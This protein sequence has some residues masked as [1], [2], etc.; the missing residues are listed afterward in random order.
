MKSS[1][2]HSSYWAKYTSGIFA[3][4]Q[5]SSEGC[6]MREAHRAMQSADVN[7][8]RLSSVVCTTSERVL[9]WFSASTNWPMSKRS[10]GFM[11]I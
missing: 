6:P 9:A 10:L 4:N 7:R 2:F 8:I 1:F 11:W 5:S 3:T